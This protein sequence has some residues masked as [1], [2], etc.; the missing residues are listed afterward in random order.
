[1]LLLNMLIAMMAETFGAVRANQEMEYSYLN[2]QIVISADLDALN[3]P[4]P[5][6]VLRLP[7]DTLVKAIKSVMYVNQK[8]REVRETMRASYSPLDESATAPEEAGAAPKRLT[9]DEKKLLAAKTPFWNDY[10]HATMPV[11]LKAMREVDFESERDSVPDLILDLK[12]ELAAAG[13]IHRQPEAEEIEVAPCT[14][15]DVQAFDGFEEEASR[16]VFHFA[17][18]FAELPKRPGKRTYLPSGVLE[19][20]PGVWPLTAAHEVEDEKL[21]KE[22][23]LRRTLTEDETAELMVDVKKLEEGLQRKAT[24]AEKLAAQAKASEAKIKLRGVVTYPFA[25]S[26]ADESEARKIIVDDKGQHVFARPNG[27][28]G[29]SQMWP[30]KINDSFFKGYKVTTNYSEVDPTVFQPQAV[31]EFERTLK[32]LFGE[33]ATK[34]SPIMYAKNSKVNKFV[35]FKGQAEAIEM[36]LRQNPEACDLLKI[37]KLYLG[38]FVAIVSKGGSPEKAKHSYKQFDFTPGEEYVLYTKVGYESM[39]CIKPYEQFVRECKLGP[40][41]QD[42]EMGI[43]EVEDPATSTDKSAARRKSFGFELVKR[44]SFASLSA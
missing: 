16:L 9:Q 18:Q 24:N 40:R 7:A 12:E 4:P 14:A 37:A 17:D 42:L 33:E 3:V 11:L 35:V 6:S 26:I 30:M 44:N 39:A 1:V 25:Q 21:E 23:K 15:A 8:V 43:S 20:E 31:A 19:N 22:M 5:F 41:R 38:G 27:T 32:C 2:S 36:F 29:V 13:S 10:T 34:R 28:H